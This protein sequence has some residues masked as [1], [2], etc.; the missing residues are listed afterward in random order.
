MKK[1]QTNINKT[2]FDKEKYSN[3]KKLMDEYS[4]IIKKIHTA[5]GVA[6]IEKQH[7][8]GRLTARER[9]DHLIDDGTS[10]FELGT[11]AAHDMYKEYGEIHCSG[12]IAGVGKIHSNEE[13]NTIL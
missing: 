8:K 1:N 9:I 7:N 4:H 5:G 13:K 3:Y 10:F 2:S 11:F 12:L 6:S